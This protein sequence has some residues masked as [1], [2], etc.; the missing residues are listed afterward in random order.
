MRPV[1]MAAV[2]TIVAGLGVA[3]LLRPVVLPVFYAI[4]FKVPSPGAQDAR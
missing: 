3:T 1:S 4:I 2:T